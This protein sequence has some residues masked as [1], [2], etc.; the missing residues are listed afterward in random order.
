MIADLIG[1][2][3]DTVRKFYSSFDELRKKKLKA[4]MQALWA[5]DPLTREL[6]GQ[7]HHP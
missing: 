3:V 1:D 4:E 7:A 6:G 5:D 2:D